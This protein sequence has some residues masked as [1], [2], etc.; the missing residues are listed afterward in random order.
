MIVAR[1]I[2]IIE[3]D[4]A[5]SELLIESLCL[6]NKFEVSVA[7]SL[8]EADALLGAD[9]VRFDAVVLDRELPDGNGH[10][11][12]AKLR[13]QGHKMPVI[14]LTGSC[15]KAD[16]V[17]GLDAGAN[18]YLTKPYHLN[19]LLARLRAQLRTFDNGEDAIVTI[20]RYAFQPAAKI[21]MDQANRRLRLTAKETA[22]LRFLYRANEPVTR[23]VLLDRVW[24]YNAGV[25]THT[26]ETHIYRL[27]QKIEIDPS[28]CR[29]LVT[30]GGGYRLNAAVAA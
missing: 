25:T 8:A 23:T 21:L 1:P 5:Q 22:I 17:R 24:G 14:F 13:L 15:D 18:D 29:L 20:G 27:R 4:H 7:T 26:L 28:D 12:C 19:E 16:L 9:G 6:D 2:L 10:D 3:D 30:E 11:Y